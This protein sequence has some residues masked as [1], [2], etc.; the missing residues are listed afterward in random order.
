MFTAAAVVAAV[1][2]INDFAS[3]LDQIDKSDKQIKL[4]VC[5]LFFF[6]FQPSV[7]V[8]QLV[9]GALRAT[10]VRGCGLAPVPS[11]LRP[12]PAAAVG[13]DCS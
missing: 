3:T 5:T 13:P 9:A 12:Q 7:F 4:S 10:D 2:F 1:A 11:A 8:G 6:F